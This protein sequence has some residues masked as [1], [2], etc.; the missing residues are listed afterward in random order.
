MGFV[1]ELSTH[2]L[3]LGIWLEYLHHEFISHINVSYRWLLIL[4]KHLGFPT[5]EQHKHL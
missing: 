2:I 5:E 4:L 3:H 1:L